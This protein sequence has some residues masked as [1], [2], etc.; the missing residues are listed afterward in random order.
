[1]IDYSKVTVGVV[2]DVLGDLTLNSPGTTVN[3]NASNPMDSESSRKGIFSK[4]EFGFST[5]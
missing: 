4:S 1:M 2:D 3:S 5:Q